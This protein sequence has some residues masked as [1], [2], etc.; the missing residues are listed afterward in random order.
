MNVDAIK[1]QAQDLYHRLENLDF[2]FDTESVGNFFTRILDAIVEF[3][4]NLFS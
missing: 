4:Q 3:F 1:E 2:H